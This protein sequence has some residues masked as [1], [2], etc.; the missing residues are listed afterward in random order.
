MNTSKR[1]PVYLNLMQIRLPV[2][3]VLSILHRITGVM[4]VIAIPL[5]IY[6]LQLLNNGSQGF[7]QATDLL[8]LTPVKMV[9]T[10]WIWMLV[11]HSLSGIRHLVQDLGYGYELATARRLAWAA[12]FTS[13]MLT[14]LFGAQLWL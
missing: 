1:R 4:L 14:L 5:I 12:F 13:A 6:L 7:E 11:Q 9:L 2:G 10:L 3:A 8:S